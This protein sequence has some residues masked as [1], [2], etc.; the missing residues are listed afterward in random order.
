MELLIALDDSEPGW[1]ALEYVLEN[2]PD[3]AVTV[4]HVIDLSRSEYGELAHLGS[5]TMRERRRER[6]DELFDAARERAAERGCEI[7]TELLVGQPAAS[8]VDY[9]VESAVDRIVVGSHGRDGISRVLLGSVAERI[10]RRAPTPVT[11]VR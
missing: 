10:A 9:A 3:D 6:A 8:I 7:E 4:V 5:E 2:H 1:N 11:I